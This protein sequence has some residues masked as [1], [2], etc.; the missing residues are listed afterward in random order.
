MVPWGGPMFPADYGGVRKGISDPKCSLTPIQIIEIQ[1]ICNTKVAN[2][3][4]LSIAGYDDYYWMWVY[5]V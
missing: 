4:S 3:L 1:H 5:W 2:S